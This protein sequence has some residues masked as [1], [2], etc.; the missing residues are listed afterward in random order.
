MY[1]WF[2]DQIQSLRDI[3]SMI[4]INISWLIFDKTTNNLYKFLKFI[5]RQ[6]SN[7]KKKEKKKNVNAVILFTASLDFRDASYVPITVILIGYPK[8]IAG[9]YYHPATSID[10]TLSTPCATF[11][12]RRIHQPLRGP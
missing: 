3:L 11:A 12:Q 10:S 5:T 2:N 6:V 1:E 4:V 9:K 8:N 7:K